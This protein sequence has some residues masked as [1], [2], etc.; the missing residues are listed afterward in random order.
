MLTRKKL[1]IINNCIQYVV[2]KISEAINNCTQYVIRHRKYI[3]I[4]HIFYFFPN[5]TYPDDGRIYLV[6]NNLLLH[7][8][9][10]RV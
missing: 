8:K 2:Y 5:S 4:Y 6:G 9:Y 7:N 1:N 10:S 3:Y